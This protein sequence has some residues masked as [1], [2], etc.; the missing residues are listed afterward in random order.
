MRGFF[1]SQPLCPILPQ[2]VPALQQGP[3]GL[4]ASPS[5]WPHQEPWV[6]RLQD[7]S[8]RAALGGGG[9]VSLAPRPA[10]P[11]FFLV[12]QSG[13]SSPGGPMTQEGSGGW[14][15]PP[16]RGSPPSPPLSQ[17]SKMSPVASQLVQEGSVP[18]LLRWSSLVTSSI[19]GELQ[20][21][22][23]ARHA[24]TWTAVPRPRSPAGKCRPQP[25]SMR[26]GPGRGHLQCSGGQGTPQAAELGLDPSTG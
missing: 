9:V 12:Q 5:S 23:R 15:Q 21:R 4:L 14:G 26:T 8:G 22:G 10:S 18:R 24:Y 19:N 7:C 3:Q 25:G 6:L 20:S 11:Q 16:R 1:G 17:M 2:P 13:E